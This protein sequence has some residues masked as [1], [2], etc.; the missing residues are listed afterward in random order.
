MRTRSISIS[1]LIKILLTTAGVSSLVAHAQVTARPDPGDPE[2]PNLSDKPDSAFKGYKPFREQPVRSWKDANQ[3][4][5]DNPGMGSMATMPGMSMPGMNMPGMDSKGAA[6]GGG[7]AERAM[8]GMGA[9]PGMNMPGMDSK[10]AP[11][12]GG[13]AEHAMSG[14]GAM[15]G[16]NMPGMDSK[17]AAA[18]GGKAKHSMP[19]MGAMAGMNMPGMDPK[20]AAAAPG[21]PGGAM[22]GM[23][24]MPAKSTMPGMNM[25]GADTKHGHEGVPRSGGS[26]PG[27]DAAGMTPKDE[28][29]PGAR[30]GGSM[31]GMAMPGMKSKS[32]ESASAILTGT[33]VVR[34]IDKPG[35]RIQ[36][37]HDPIADV[38]WPRMTIFFR[39]KN[40]SLVD[41]TKPGD[42]VKFVLTKSSAG[43]VIS[44]IQSVASSAANP[45]K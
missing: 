9:M 10:S 25:A 37:T 21:K 22:Q 32:E 42:K 18:A 38:S 26:M 14:M 24:S 31:P 34:A 17:G 7:K 29:A 40:A 43:Y 28:H 4:V 35:S 8:S 2:A 36:L 5:A 33:G 6:A 23:G 11:A 27:M 19:G 39:V 12:A 30:A 13:K 16:M 1:I 45:T 3:E 44:D 41:Q 20:G 15:P